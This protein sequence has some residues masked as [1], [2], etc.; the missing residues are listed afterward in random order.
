MK[1]TF[2]MRLLVR[3]NIPVCLLPRGFLGLGAEG[4]GEGGEEVEV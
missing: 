3:Y 1:H 2:I 4:A